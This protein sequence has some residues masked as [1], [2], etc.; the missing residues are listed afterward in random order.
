VT[1]ASLCET[2]DRDIDAERDSLIRLCAELV[3]A[4]SINPPGRTAEMA[5]VVK[6]W[7]D[8][9]GVPA[10][11][12]AADAE[13][14]NV[15]GSVACAGPGRHVVFNAHMDTM[16]PGDISAWSAPPFELTRRDARLFGLGMGNMKGALAAMCVATAA[17]HRH[18]QEL[19]GR[20]TLTA[21]SDEVMFGERGTVLLLRERPDLAGDF[22]ISGEGP[23]FMDLAVAEKG[24][25]W[26][27]ITVTGPAG[28]ASRA[29]G[30][31][32]AVMRLA[33]LLSRLDAFNDIHAALPP[34]LAGVS[35]GAD[36]LGFRLSLNAGNLAAGTVRSQIATRAVAKLDIR[37]PPGLSADDIEGRVRAIAASD[38]DICIERVKAWD[39]N[40]TAPASE[41]A[42]TVAAAATAVRGQAPQPVV[43]LPGSD[44]RKW[45]ALGVP[46][47]CYG[48]Q[49][50]LSS[51]IDDNALEQDVIDCAKIYARTA[52]GLMG[53]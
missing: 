37:L 42:V 21:V 38:P 40:W 33:A 18:L 15:V 6:A 28:H 46:A 9:R 17:I 53:G 25:L 3:G 34:E 51:G 20:L 8:A 11:I 19:A 48:P 39:A 30:G 7:L 29:F 31:Q 49:P 32:T 50:T 10:E 45:R 22:L 44:A 12:V 36:D 24:L 5:A 52:I 13:A 4:V 14:P 41:L 43:R 2:I 47:V 16:E 26:L 27:D 35:G 1:P 23:G